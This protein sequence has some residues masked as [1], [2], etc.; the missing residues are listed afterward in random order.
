VHA[1]EEERASAL[2]FR[3]ELLERLDLRR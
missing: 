1:S 2:E 3:E